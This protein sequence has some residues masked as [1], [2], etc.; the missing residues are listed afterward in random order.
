MF[1]FDS[2]HALTNRWSRAT[3]GGEHSRAILWLRRT[4]RGYL[5][6]ERPVRLQPWAVS[7]ANTKHTTLGEKIITVI[8]LMLLVLFVIGLLF[9]LDVIR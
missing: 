2:R 4:S 3:V 9:F 8:A 1:A 5:C 7:M 6:P